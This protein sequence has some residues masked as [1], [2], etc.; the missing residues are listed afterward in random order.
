[1]E[2]G[3]LKEYDDWFDSLSERDQQTEIAATRKR[4]EAYYDAMA[5]FLVWVVAKE[6]HDISAYHPLAVLTRQPRRQARSGPIKA[7]TPPG[8]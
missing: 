7:S 6:G 2:Q 5:L 8:Q 4:Y 1:M 3:R